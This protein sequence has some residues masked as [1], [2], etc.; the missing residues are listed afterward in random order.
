M[1]FKE[2]L[3]VFLIIVG[4]LVSGAGLIAA[5]DEGDLTMALFS[6]GILALTFLVF[7]WHPG[8]RAE[9]PLF[10][11]LDCHSIGQPIIT[12][13]GSLW[14]EVFL[15]ILGG[16]PGILYSLWRLTTRSQV[17]PRCGKPSMIP[18]DTPR[19]KELLDS[20]LHSDLSIH[21]ERS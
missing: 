20:L 1:L 11:C 16:F 13:R 17:C 14:L 5:L 19:G 4:V 21:G 3:R 7:R 9:K 10:V 18:A 8:E 6:F 15:W 2:V 12:V